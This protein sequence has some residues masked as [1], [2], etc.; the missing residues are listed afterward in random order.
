MPDWSS[1]EEARTVERVQGEEAVDPHLRGGA[2]GV[3]VGAVGIPQSPGTV[4]GENL[5]PA[6]RTAS[7]GRSVSRCSSAIDVVA[8]FSIGR[9]RRSSSAF[10]S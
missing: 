2:L 1:V 6:A 7:L 8:R 5:E 10:G 9:T 4:V 3:C